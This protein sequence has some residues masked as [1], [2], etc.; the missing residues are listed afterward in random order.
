MYPKSNLVDSNTVQE[1]PLNV[2]DWTLPVTLQRSVN[3]VETQQPITGTRANRSYGSQ[4]SIDFLN[5]APAAGE[6]K[7]YD[8]NRLLQP[9]REAQTETPIDGLDRQRPG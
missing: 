5:Q 3:V 4:F 8:G 7:G 2:L 9:E 6:K 1:L